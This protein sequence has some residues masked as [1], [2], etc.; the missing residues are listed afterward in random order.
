MYD[1]EQY[2]FCKILDKMTNPIWREKKYTGEDPESQFKHHFLCSS[3][4]SRFFWGKFHRSGMIMF[5]WPFFFLICSAD[6]SPVRNT[7]REPHPLVFQQGTPPE[8]RQRRRG[9]F[10]CWSLAWN[11][12]DQVQ[13]DRSKR[14]ASGVTNWSFL[15]GSSVL[16]SNI[17]TGTLGFCSVT[18]FNWDF[19]VIQC[20]LL[21]QIGH[22][23]EYMWPAS[24][25]K[26]CSGQQGFTLDQE[27]MQLLW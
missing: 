6:S 14:R 17:G 25:S 10:Y 18:H 23:A 27:S 20:S 13:M 1:M 11:G 12:L 15:L 19:I 3:P 2:S 22:C 7:D 8:I 24:Q 26:G 16:H 21:S 4:S 5:I 9:C